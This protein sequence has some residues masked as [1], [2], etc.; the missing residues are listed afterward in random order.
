MQDAINF[1]SFNRLLLP[2]LLI[3]ATTGVSGKARAAAEP[4]TSWTCWYSRDSAIT[5]ELKRAPVA[6][7]L[8]EREKAAFEAGGGTAPTAARSGSLPHVV[9]VLRDRPGALAGKQVRIPLHTEPTDMVFV[10]QLAQAVMCG[11]RAACRV[12][13]GP[14][15]FELARLSP[16]DLVDRTDAAM[17]D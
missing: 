4:E 3:A 12:E 8:V 5:C 2:I 1:P 7:A 9:Q 14:T 16:A 10:R 11:S 15:I 6:E 13:F 17:E